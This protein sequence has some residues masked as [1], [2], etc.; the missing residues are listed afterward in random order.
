MQVVSAYLILTKCM[1]NSRERIQAI[2]DQLT[3]AQQRYETIG[4]RIRSCFS[5]SELED[6]AVEAALQKK[7]IR[8]LEQKKNNITVVEYHPSV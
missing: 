4:A 6:L 5:P 1:Q 8:Q 7:L 3:I 2:T